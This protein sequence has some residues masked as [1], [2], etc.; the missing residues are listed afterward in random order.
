MRRSR[1]AQ[2]LSAQ[3]AVVDAYAT[4]P[5]ARSRDI[6]THCLGLRMIFSENRYPPTDQVSEDKLFGSMRAH[7][8]RRTGDNATG[9]FMD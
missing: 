4:Q 6:A 8:C 1:P 9:F 5:F 7:T 2:D 3:A